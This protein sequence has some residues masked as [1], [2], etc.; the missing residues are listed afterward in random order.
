MS[1]RPSPE[2]F[3]R[4]SYFLALASSII[5]FITFIVMLI[6]R[7]LSEALVNIVWL[8]LVTSGAGTFLAYAARADFRRNPGAPDAVRQARIGWRVN[9]G[10]L[11]VVTI[12]ALFNIIL[13]LLT[14]S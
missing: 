2:T 4:Y 3:A 7:P 9:L 14:S 12:T 11:A 10:A 8:A 13:K 5:L 1:S 6:P